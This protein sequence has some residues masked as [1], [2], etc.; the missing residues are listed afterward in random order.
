MHPQRAR[1]LLLRGK[2]VRDDGT[3]PDRYVLVRDGRIA[4]ISRR[5]PPR[6]G[7]ALYLETGPDDWVFPGL[8]DLHTHADYN[9]LPLWEAPR[10]YENRFQWRADPGY[11]NDVRGLA[12]Y[13][14]RPDEAHAQ[15][16]AH[17]RTIAVF[18]ELQAVAGGTA[19]LQ[20]GRSLE[21]EAGLG[22]PVLC[23][24]TANPEDLGLPGDA[25]VLS[26]VDFFRPDDAGRPAPVDWAF[27]AYLT[28][29]DAGRLHATLAH[30]A[31]G[32]S[33]FG[34][35]AGPDP[36]SR[37]EFAAFMAHPAF[38]DA[39][40]VRS[41][42]LA[43]IH[44][45]GIDVDDERHLAF[46]RERGISVIWSP[47][48]NL[49]LYGETLDVEKLVAAGVNVALG[50]DWSPSGS[51]HVWDEA[52]LARFYFEAIGSA[53]SDVQVF[54]MVTTNAARCLGSDRLGRLVEGAMADFFILRS[55]LES[56]VAL[57][58]F[59]KTADRHVRGVFIG[60]VPLYG[61]RDFLAPCGLP[62]QGLPA[63]EGSAVEGKAVYL[64][65][66]L[67]K[68]D[69]EPIDVDRDVTHLEDL[70]KA[71]PPPLP[72]TRR[73]N[74]LASSDGP[75]R[76]RLIRLRQDVVDY[77]GRVQEWRRRRR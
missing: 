74:L 33:G 77:G 1:P 72:A 5:R 12:E 9:L 48:S 57:E 58:V 2:V 30:L 13:L 15:E 55:P 63:R 14:A 60:G 66:Q 41:S 49:L 34:A 32:R 20:E 3:A 7:D 62:L 68:A 47:V 28:A 10:R 37:A 54:R 39:G 16:K 31:E 69:G 23:R 52:K 70:L 56:D 53:V 42:P 38:A 11:K 59:F 21:R 6:S 45:C 73:S 35:E 40:R 19:T 65:P 24:S 51:K 17:A 61:A 29:R 25:Q 46:L 76:R 64:P 71:A 67:T 75:Y 22:E 27:E 43:L 50:S 44:G 26:L 4:S 8:L 36:Y 18:S